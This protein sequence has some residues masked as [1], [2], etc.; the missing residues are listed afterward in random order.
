ME[1][2]LCFCERN[3]FEKVQGRKGE[4]FWHCPRCQLIFRPEHEHVST[5]EEKERYLTHN[6]KMENKGYVEFLLRPYEF[7]KDY[8]HSTQTILDYG[9]GFNPVFAQLMEKKGWNCDFYDPLFFPQG[10]KRSRYSN[11][12]CIE[13]VEHFKFPHKDWLR[14][15]HLLAQEG[16]LTIMTD[17]WRDQKDFPHWYYINDKTHLSFYHMKT[18]EWIAENYGWNIIDSD[19]KRIIVFKK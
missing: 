17:L 6:N 19:K 3:E 10:V 9:C 14:L 13:T 2:P 8:L 1:C 11:I 15:H 12:F 7:S 5:A 18:M 4:F 16:V